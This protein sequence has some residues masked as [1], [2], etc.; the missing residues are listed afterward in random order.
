MV[1]WR[2]TIGTPANPRTH[3]D[4]VVIDAK[5]GRP[6]VL[7]PPLDGAAR[8]LLFDRPAW[9]PDGRLIAFTVELDGDPAAPYRTDIYLMDADGSRVRRL[10]RSERALLPVWSPDGRT[11]AFAKRASSRPRSFRDLVSTI[12]TIGTDGSNE[13]QLVPSSGLTADTPGAWSPNGESLAF[14]RRTYT[15]P[16]RSFESS[17]A[18]Y[19]VASDG[20]GL[21]QLIEQGSEPAWS[22]DG[23]LIAFVSDRDRN[24]ELS[25]GD[26]TSYANEL[27]VANAD[28]SEPKRLTKTRDL[29]ERSPAWSPDGTRI[30]YTRGEQF[31][32][33]EAT[34]VLIIESDGDCPSEIASNDP[35]GAWYANAVWRPAQ[36]RSRFTPSC[37]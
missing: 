26:Q 15:D 21:R 37:L 24:G 6:R 2:A 5:H 27:Y 23:R 32:N 25:Y 14:T 16:G 33:A 1:M 30:A 8:P 11:I 19:V 17:E 18:I 31:H 10:T 28:G 35:N 20:S 36:S 34:S 7:T 4:I 3:Y 12:W 29:N 9:S 22:P 13:R